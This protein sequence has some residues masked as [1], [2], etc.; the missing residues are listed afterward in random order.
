MKLAF[1]LDLQRIRNG[2]PKY[3]IRELF[4]KRYPNLNIPDKIPMPRAT[5][6]WLKNYTP[7]RKEFKI[8]NIN[9]LTGDQ[10]WLIYCLETFLNMHD[11]GEL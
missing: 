10:K 1:P 7:T 11:K 2:E 3:L 5:E 9:I 8:E 4:S 6:Q